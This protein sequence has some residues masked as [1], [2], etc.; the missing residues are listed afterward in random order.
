MISE[1]SLGVKTLDPEDPDYV[2]Y[3]DNS[4]DSHNRKTAHGYSYH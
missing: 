3:Y 1:H 2:S 4:D